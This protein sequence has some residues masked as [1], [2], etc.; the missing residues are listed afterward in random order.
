MS[1]FKKDSPDSVYVLGTKEAC[2]KAIKYGWIAAVIAA[3]IT[4]IFAILGFFIHSDN[5]TIQYA[6]DPLLLIDAVLIA[7]LAVFIFRKSRVAATLLF[8]YFVASKI[9]IWMDTHSFSGGI[10]AVLF[11]FLF[12]NAARATFIWHSKYKNP[13]PV[14]EATVSINTDENK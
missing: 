1:I 2:E 13:V 3:S 6:F 14:Q 5:P 10:L 9:M 4:F 12:G 7:V 11:I 8:I